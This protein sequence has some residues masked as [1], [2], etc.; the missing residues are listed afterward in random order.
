MAVKRNN[1]GNIE[2]GSGKW[3]GLTPAQGHRFATFS[4]VTWGI[5]AIA[6]TLIAYQDKHK[7]RTI[8]AAISR[9]APP[10]DANN[11]RK[12]IANVSAWTGFKPSQ[13]L[14]FHTWEHLRPVV[15]AII[16]Q[17]SGVD[18]GVSDAQLDKG[19]VMAGVQPPERP[20]RT[21]ASA[22]VA[23]AATVSAPL[24]APV[25]DMIASVQPLVE[26]AA[27][28]VGTLQSVAKIAP[29]AMAVV[30]LAAIAYIVYAR[31]DD[32]RRGLR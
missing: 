8:S 19:L 13:T 4:D 26:Q 15:R 29:W 22:K 20:S 30:A 28:V 27:P 7:I 24:A 2:L 11:T 6:V 25:L 21:V 14:N 3:Q 23:A 16:T 9:Y 18:H 17:E 1:P 32:K 10:D 5:R 31:I 12:Y